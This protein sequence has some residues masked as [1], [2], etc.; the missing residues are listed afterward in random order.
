MD[1]F[2]A[3]CQGIGLAL[4]AGALGGALA[5]AFGRSPAVRGVLLAAAVIGAAILFGASL[6][7]ADHPAWPGWPVG[8]LIAPL[9][10]AVARG[11]VEGASA[12]AAS[13]AEGAEGTPASIA[14]TV[15]VVAVAIAA[16]ATLLSPVSLLV[17]AGFAWLAFARRRQAQRKYEGLRVLR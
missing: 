17:L 3:T 15:A 16:L 13:G 1:S 6:T 9:G 11:V 10:F 5:G 14:L 8:A 4:A 2:L 12:R 7:T